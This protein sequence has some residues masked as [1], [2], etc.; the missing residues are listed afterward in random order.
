MSESR[1]HD[2]LLE[3]QYDEIQE[4]DNPLPAWWTIILWATI[5][6]AVLYALNVIPGVGSARAGWRTTRPRW[7]AATEKYGAPGSRPARRSPR[8]DGSALADPG[9]LAAG[10][11]TFVQNC[12]RATCRTAAATS[13][14][15]TDDLLDPRQHPPAD[16][17]VV[18]NGVLD[19]GMRNG[20]PC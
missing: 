14:N 20:A 1:E 18:T 19:K 9:A 17:H 3:H 13:P 16:A 5:V 8:G 7:P 10:K 11:A 6:W 12:A 15:L 2:R 4:Y